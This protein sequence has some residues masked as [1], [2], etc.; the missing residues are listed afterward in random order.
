[1]R[2]WTHN[3]LYRVIVAVHT[4]IRVADNCLKVEL[5]VCAKNCRA[6]KSERGRRLP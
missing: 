4:T 3:H 2:E 6:C 1:M 5:A